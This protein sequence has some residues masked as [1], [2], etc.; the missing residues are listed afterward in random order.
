MMIKTQRVSL[1]KVLL[2][3][4]QFK[5]SSSAAGYQYSKI[6]SLQPFLEPSLCLILAVVLRSVVL[7]RSS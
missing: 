3:S 5:E 6:C 2:F 1:E 7:I 4:S